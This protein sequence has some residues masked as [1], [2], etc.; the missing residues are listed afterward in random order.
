LRVFG[1][2]C[3]S[4][5]GIIAESPAETGLS[6]FETK[7]RRFDGKIKEISS[8]GRL[9]LDL[10]CIFLAPNAGNGWRNPQTVNDL[11]ADCASNPAFRSGG[12]LT[13]KITAE[14]QREQR[15]PAEV[16]HGD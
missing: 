11:N 15:G 10:A 8:L 9:V 2:D 13:R 3:A 12:H 14:A 5:A 6:S 7:R 1:H 4:T 16:G